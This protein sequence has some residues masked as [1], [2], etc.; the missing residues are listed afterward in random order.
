MVGGCQSCT[1]GYLV[2]NKA[3][4]PTI[5]QLKVGAFTVFARFKP[6]STIYVATTGQRKG[7]PGAVYSVRARPPCTLRA[8]EGAVRLSPG[9]RPAVE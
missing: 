2:I 4:L 7:T 5:A 1:A 9:R 8:D 6:D 3:H